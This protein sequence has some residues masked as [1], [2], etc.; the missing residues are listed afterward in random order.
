MS[1]TRVLLVH[2]VLLGLLL[3]SGFDMLVGREHWP[4]SHYPM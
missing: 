2:C 3:G 1:R 4:F